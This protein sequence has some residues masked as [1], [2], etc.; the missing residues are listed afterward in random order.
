MCLGCGSRM[1]RLTGGLWLGRCRGRHSLGP[2]GKR[3]ALSGSVAHGQGTKKGDPAAKF[4]RARH[5]AALGVHFAFC[6]FL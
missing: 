2:K 4:L 3:Q 5:L 6:D 1:C